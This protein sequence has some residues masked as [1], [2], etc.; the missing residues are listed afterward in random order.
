MAERN[1]IGLRKQICDLNE[2][3]FRWHRDHVPYRSTADALYK[4][5]VTAYN[6]MGKGPPSYPIETKLYS[7]KNNKCYSVYGHLAYCSNECTIL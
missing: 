7:G 2:P 6:E 3:H 4:F 1:D 5:T